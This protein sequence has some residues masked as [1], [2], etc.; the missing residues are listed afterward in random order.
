MVF[1][2]HMSDNQTARGPLAAMM[3]PGRHGVRGRFSACLIIVVLAVCGWMMHR[4]LSQYDAPQQAV[5]QSAAIKACLTRRN[6]IS[7]PSMRGTEAFA[8]FFRTFALAATPGSLDNSEASLALWVQRNRWDRFSAARIL[9]S[10]AHFFFLP[11]PSLL[12]VL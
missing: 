9:P 6:P 12:P 4:R 3:P 2:T 7:V 10:L 5:H 1:K 8:V 11:P